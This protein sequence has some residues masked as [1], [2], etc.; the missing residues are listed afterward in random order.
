[1][2]SSQF[3]QSWLLASA[4]STCCT[5]TGLTSWWGSLRLSGCGRIKQ[6]VGFNAPQ[7]C[8]LI[9]FFVPPSKL[10]VE[11]INQK[12]P[13]KSGNLLPFSGEN[14]TPAASSNQQKSAKRTWMKAKPT[15]RATMSVRTTGLRCRIA[16]KIFKN[17]PTKLHKLGWN[18]G[19]WCGNLLLC[20]SPMALL[21]LFLQSG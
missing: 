12:I 16:S 2:W 3:A 19:R 7:E 15:F 18:F 13:G 6:H 5:W 4:F 17:N 8:W 10:R 1:M 20:Q 9:V 21:V 14:E 11:T